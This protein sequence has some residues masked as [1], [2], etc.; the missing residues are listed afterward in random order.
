M[1]TWS[2][3][4]HPA[5]KRNAAEGRGA[6]SYF[7]LWLSGVAADGAAAD[8]LLSRAYWVA[9]SRSDAAI[10]TGAFT[11]SGRWENFSTRDGHRRL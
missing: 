1:D 10:I 4:D 2:G 6:G 5:K 9:I 3:E 8:T 7:S 11:S